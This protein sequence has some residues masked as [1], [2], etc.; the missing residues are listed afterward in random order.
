MYLGVA[1][2]ANMVF[3]ILAT[4]LNAKGA[5]NATMRFPE[6]PHR[7]DYVL[8]AVIPGTSWIIGLS[9]PFELWPE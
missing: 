1:D 8:K 5:R 9:E 4:G 7:D 3:S 2:N 6:L